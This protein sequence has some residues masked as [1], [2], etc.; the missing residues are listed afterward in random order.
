LKRAILGLGQAWRSED[1]FGLAALEYLRQQPD[2]LNL[3]CDFLLSQGNLTDM[4]EYFQSYD[5]ILI[6][7]AVWIE[8]TKVIDHN[9]LVFAKLENLIAGHK[10]DHCVGTHFFS[11]KEIYLLA[12]TLGT[13][14]ADIDFLGQSIKCQKIAAPLET[15]G[16]F[17]FQEVR[18]KVLDWLRS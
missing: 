14:R 8:E 18:E 2:L 3:D 16:N 12:K 7:D 15:M 5:R 17:P 11:L 6:I 4:T 1:N 10:L 9:Q 13:L